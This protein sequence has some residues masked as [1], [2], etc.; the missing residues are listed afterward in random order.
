VT[1]TYRDN[2][3]YSY[4]ADLVREGKC[5][6]CSGKGTRSAQGECKTTGEVYDR[7]PKCLACVGTGKPNEEMLAA[8]ADYENGI[9]H[10]C[11]LP[12]VPGHGTELKY[13]PSSQNDCLDHLRQYVLTLEERVA[14]LEARPRVSKAQSRALMML[15]PLGG[16]R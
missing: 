2:N 9:C 13:G 6:V 10:G 4:A 1:K 15:T 8:F 7:D 5:T 14:K 3:L 12:L 11:K 16:K